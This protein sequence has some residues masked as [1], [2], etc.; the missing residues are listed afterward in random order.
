MEEKNTTENTI[1]FEFI[2]V[3]NRK[4]TNVSNEIKFIIKRDNSRYLIRP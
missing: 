4:C 2:I 3:V 1:I